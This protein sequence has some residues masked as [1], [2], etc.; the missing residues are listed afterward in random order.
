[1]HSYFIT[2]IKISEIDSIEE[3]SEKNRT[4]FDESV[5]L[6]NLRASLKVDEL[7]LKIATTTEQPRKRLENSQTSGMI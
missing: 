4:T 7:A 1:M 3:N 6:Q 2:L 5:I